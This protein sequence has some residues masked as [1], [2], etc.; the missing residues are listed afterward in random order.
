MNEKTPE[1][2][3]SEA[4][5]RALSSITQPGRNA[6]LAKK[7]DGENTIYFSDITVIY[8][9]M[10]PHR[11]VLLLVLLLA[12]KDKASEMRFEPWATESEGR[13]LRMFY[14]VEG[15]LHELVPPPQHLADTILH[16][17]KAVAGFYSMRRRLADWLRRLASKLDSQTQ[18]TSQSR[19]RMKAGEEFVEISSTVY[20]SPTGDRIF[21]GIP[22]CSSSL[23]QKAQEALKAIFDKRKS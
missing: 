16:E 18:Q 17:V 11:R 22:S 12:L 6:P 9:S 3:E 14:E 7:I 5:E 13:A 4:V 21:L 20:G 8:D 2:E 23:S 1:Q 15:Q 10:P 19:F